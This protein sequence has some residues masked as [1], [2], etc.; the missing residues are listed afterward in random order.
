MINDI[1]SINN[2]TIY[3]DPY[4]QKD[5]VLMGNKGN[6]NFSD[7]RDLLTKINA[8]ADIIHSSY[9]N[10]G[11]NFIVVSSEIAEVLKGL[12][13]NVKEDRNKKLKRI[14]NDLQI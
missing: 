8:S 12:I 14:F 3:E 2:I 1:G 4:A 9:K 13:K 11:A 7:T 10:G 5:T 6:R